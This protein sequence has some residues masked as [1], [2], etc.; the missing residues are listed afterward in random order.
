ML[1]QVFNYNIKRTV[2]YVLTFFNF[3]L[4]LFL[5]INTFLINVDLTSNLTE[6]L[7]N[8]DH[9]LDSSRKQTGFVF[10]RD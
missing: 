8:W 5:R 10:L 9:M 1:N 3:S 6:V 2:T 7:I 4:V